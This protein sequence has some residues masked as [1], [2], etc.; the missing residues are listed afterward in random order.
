VL[1]AILVLIIVVRIRRV[2]NGTRVSTAR[3]SAYIVYYVG[4]AAL[5]LTG[6]FFAGVSSDFFAIYAS[7]F[8]LAAFASY[9]L[10]R[11][12]LVFWR[13]L[14]GAIYSKGALPIY[15]TYVA[16]LIVRIA[17]G[18]IFIGPNFLFQISTTPLS[19]TALLATIASDILLVVG[20]G[21]LVGRNVQ[22]I[23][24]YRAIKS[25]REQV[26]DVAESTN[27]P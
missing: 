21:L 17:I 20:A 27:A 18:F 9:S 7:V 5:I 14:D 3:A 15:L 11:G 22:L 4:F 25:N 8:A 26:S 10:A 19:G 13:G 2:I 6:S 1:V 23:T 16:G 12:M 24:R